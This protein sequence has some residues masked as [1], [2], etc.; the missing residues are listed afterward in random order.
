MCQFLLSDDRCVCTGG[1]RTVDPIRE[2]NALT[3]LQKAFWCSVQL[4]RS[5]MALRVS[6]G[7][8]P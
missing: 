6:T 4:Q 8:G 5:D 3:A 7:S 2:L 1:G